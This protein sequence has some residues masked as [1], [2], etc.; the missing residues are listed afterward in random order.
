MTRPMFSIPP[1]SL[2]WNLEPPAQCGTRNLG[3][4]EPGPRP[5]GQAGTRNLEPK[6]KKKFGAPAARRQNP[7]PGTRSHG[8]AEPE[9]RNCRGLVLSAVGIVK[10]TRTLVP[11]LCLNFVCF[12]LHIIIAALGRV[13][14]CLFSTTYHHRCPWARPY[15]TFLSL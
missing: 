4:S 7:E 6:L 12:R 13:L 3:T 1:P 9:P 2:A 10:R 8:G 15:I 11:S 5:D 14:T